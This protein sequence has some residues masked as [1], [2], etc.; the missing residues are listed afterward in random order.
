[1]DNHFLLC[2]ITHPDEVA[3]EAVK[4]TAAL[5]HGFDW[6]HLRK[7]T[8]SYRDVRNL[9]EAIPQRLWRKLR[10]HGHFILLDEFNLGG[11]QLNAKHPRVPYN[12]LTVTRSCHSIAEANDC[13][14]LLYVTLSPIYDSISK[15]G[16]KSA[17]DLD[18]IQI[19][20]N[21]VALGGVTPDKFEQLQNIG[22]AG[23]ALLGSMNWQ[24]PTEQFIENIDLIISK[25]KC[26]N[27]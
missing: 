18:T 3:D 14:D 12:A 25:R 8:W 16:Y 11:V 10:L 6:I 27:S 9:I 20:K 1:M 5:D 24:L 4:I 26:Y 21:V 13:A 19:G 15:T 23:A 17:F 2:G 22:F 7:P